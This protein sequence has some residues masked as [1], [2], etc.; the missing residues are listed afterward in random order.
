MTDKLKSGERFPEMSVPQLGGGDL[1]LGVPL[2]RLIHRA[3]P[4]GLAEVA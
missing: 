2:A 3:V 4:E 1:R